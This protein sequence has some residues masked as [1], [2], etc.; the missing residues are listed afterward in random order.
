MKRSTWPLPF[1]TRVVLTSASV[2][3]ARRPSDSQG[4]PPLPR[5][6]PSPGRAGPLGDEAGVLACCLPR[7]LGEHSSAWRVGLGDAFAL[8]HELGSTR[9]LLGRC[10]SELQPL[11]H[12]HLS[13]RQ[14]PRAPQL[15][16]QGRMQAM[17]DGDEIV[18]VR[19]GSAPNLNVTKDALGVGDWQREV[20][21]PLPAITA[22]ATHRLPQ[23]P[24]A[25]QLPAR[26][27]CCCM[28]PL[29]SGDL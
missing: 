22:T 28:Q 14:T 29:A 1:R 8:V 6:H 9:V 3:L 13:D 23:T 16:P 25:C 5:D 4:F 20:R 11:P 7:G 26:S 12:P 15:G 21:T 27:A 2:L 17:L 24:R 10:T 19:D 18:S